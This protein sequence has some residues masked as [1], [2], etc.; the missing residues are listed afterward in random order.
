MVLDGVQLDVQVVGDLASRV[1]HTLVVELST[2]QMVEDVRLA[3]AGRCPVAFYGRQG[4]MV[5]T[6]EEIVEQVAA[7]IA[8]SSP[9]KEVRRAQALA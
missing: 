8:G 1:R 2:G 5:P 6:A 9:G 7:V 4:G 3:V